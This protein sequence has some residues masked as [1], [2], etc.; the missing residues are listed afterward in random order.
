VFFV[1]RA[2]NDHELR[3]RSEAA[4]STCDHAAPRRS[5]FGHDRVGVVCRASV[6]CTPYRNTAVRDVT[7][8]VRAHESSSAT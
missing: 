1:S 7:V 4:R 6:A 8:A 5:S 2:V 3:R